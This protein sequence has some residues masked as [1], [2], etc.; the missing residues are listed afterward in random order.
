[1][2]K[3]VTRKSIRNNNETV[4]SIGYCAVQYTLNSSR[5]EPFA[6]SRGVN[7]W[8]CDYYKIYS[9]EGE[10]IIISTGYQ[11]TSNFDFPTYYNFTNKI[12]SKVNSLEWLDTDRMKLASKQL[13]LLADAVVAYKNCDLGYREKSI[14]EN[15]DSIKRVKTDSDYI[16]IRFTD[17]EGS[18]FECGKTPGGYKITN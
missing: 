3:L 1:M 12:E 16:I 6:Y 17:T 13:T 9:S 5:L 11:P 7:G 10:E 15:L 4:I 14:M 2:K 18:S 8:A